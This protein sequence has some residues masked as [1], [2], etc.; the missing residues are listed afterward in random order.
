MQT[1]YDL[2]LKVAQHLTGK[3]P[4]LRYREP[5]Y[6]GNIA[7]VQVDETGRPVIDIS[8]I[9]NGDERELRIFLHELAHIRLHKFMRSNVEQ[10][11]QSVQINEQPVAHASREKQAD[12]LAL[13]WLDYG[14]KH[15][16][17][18]VIPEFE[19]ILWAL[20]NWKATT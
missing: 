13:R 15:Q 19:G 3:R 20:L 10:P 6:K 8:P 17:G 5:I 16:P 4:A 1:L 9:L 11:P 12:D 18:G 7:C 2:M 14:R